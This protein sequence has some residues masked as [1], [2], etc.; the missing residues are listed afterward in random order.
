MLYAGA[1]L[2]S[3][4]D[5]GYRHLLPVLPFLYIAIG[6]RTEKTFEEEP[7]S[8]RA[9]TSKVSAWTLPSVAPRVVL[10]GLLLWLAVGTL[11]TLPYPLTFFNEIAGG[12]ANGYRA[13]VDSNLDWGQ[14]LWDLKAWMAAHGISHVAYAHYSPARP[15]TYGIE[16]DW[17]PP[18]PRAVSFDPWHPAPGLYAIGATVLQGPYAPDLNTFAWFRDRTPVA[19]LGN[20]LFLY[21]VEERPAPAWAELCT[22][23]ISA[24]T[25]R[26]RVGVDGLRVVQPACG[27]A[28]VIPASETPGLIVLPPDLPTPDVGDPL[29]SLRNADGDTQAIVRS[30][31]A[32]DVRP[33][34]PAPVGDTLIGPLTYLGTT[35]G[36]SAAGTPDVLQIQTY[37]RVVDVPA[38][39][40]SLMA[41]LVGPDGTT[42]CRWRR[43]GL[44]DRPMADRRRHRAD[45]PLRAGRRDAA[46]RGDLAPDRRLLVGHAR[47]LAHDRRWRQHHGRPEIGAVGDRW[48]THSHTGAE[49]PRA[50]GRGPDVLLRWALRPRSLC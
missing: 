37:W 43:D 33:E 12:P 42:L 4:V 17:L 8:A 14:N 1:S 32:D 44:P 40:L 28:F 10:A 16:A 23:A 46:G 47:T 3:T 13:L 49:T 41:H 29:L 36:A 35:V 20:A 11:A 6:S 39:P 27:Q 9:E 24:D 26:R 50:I 25:I 18:D 48:T 22:Q 31:S 15:D 5:I 34:A 21:R 2:F 7:E 19:K 38:R 30:V 45:A